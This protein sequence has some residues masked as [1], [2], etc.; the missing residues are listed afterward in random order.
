MNEKNSWP[1]R[2]RRVA[3]ALTLGMLLSSCPSLSTM[4]TAR[5]IGLDETEFSG[6]VGVFGFDDDHDNGVVPIF[7]G[8]VRR[9]F[10]ERYDAGLRI[11]NFSM[12]HADLNY[13]LVMND[14]F[15]L[16]VDP[17]ISVIPVGDSL[18]SYVCL[19]ILVDVV[20]TEDMTVTLSARYGYFSLDGYADSDED[21]FGLT[22][23]TPLVG[24]GI[25][26][27]LRAGG[28]TW[29]PELHMIQATD[30]SIDSNTLYAFSL[31]FVF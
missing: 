14:D 31:G 15:V 6:V 7:E 8:Q 21:D 1:S 19:P 26:L 16:S 27:R 22:E 5:P 13:A 28:I 12:L 29:M 4:H 17:T 18:V 23:S 30:D 2:A 20:R 10:G 11:S 24:F 25:G 3:G 9:G